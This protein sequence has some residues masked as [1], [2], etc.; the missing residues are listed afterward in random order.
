MPSRLSFLLRSSLVL[1]LPALAVACG[2]AMDNK[3]PIIDSL[4][5]PLVVSERDGS[6]AIPVTVLFHDNDGEAITHIH[7]RLPPNIDGMI[8]V[9]APN[10]TRESATV[11]L[12]I[13]ADELDGYAPTTRSRSDGADDE[14]SAA[15]T[16]NDAKRTGQ[17]ARS[18]KRSLELSIVDFRGAESLPE[19]KTLTLD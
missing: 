10:P 11:T 12:V 13:R 4:D 3:A 15:K 8:D 5:A 17:R 2:D 19:S 9:H 16:E 18:R 14:K 1:A 7:Y 6:Y